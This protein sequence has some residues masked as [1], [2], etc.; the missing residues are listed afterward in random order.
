MALDL[1]NQQ[2]MTHVA[3]T[4]SGISPDDLPYIFDRYYRVNS[5]Q[6]ASSTGAGLGLAITKRILELHGSAIE[7]QSVVH[8]GTTFSF[9]LPVAQPSNGPG[10]SFATES[11]PRG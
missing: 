1:E 10:T 2:I 5:G 9:H 4:G 8:K 6:R 7:V 11:L 3:D